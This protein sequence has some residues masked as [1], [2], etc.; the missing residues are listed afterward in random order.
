M[1][2]MRPVMSRVLRPLW[3]VFAGGVILLG[4]LSAGLRIALPLLAAQ[5]A[6]VE[7]W[8]SDL[9]H[10][11]VAIEGLGA[12]WPG[13]LPH[14][15]L[16]GLRIAPDTAGG[17]AITCRRVELTLAPLD[18][19]RAREPVLHAVTLDGLRLSVQRASDGRFSVQGIPS[20]NP[21]FLAWLLRQE[22]VEAWDTEIRFEDLAEANAPIRV[23]NLDLRLQDENG[24]LVARGRLNG[25]GLLGENAQFEL[26]RPLGPGAGTTTELRLALSATPIPE[27]LAAVGHPLTTETLFDHADGRLWLRWD[28]DRL[29]RVAADMKLSLAATRRMPGFELVHVRGV[30]SQ[31]PAG[32]AAQ[33]DTLAAGPSVEAGPGHPVTLT[34][35]Q[36]RGYL[37]ADALPLDLLTL[38]PHSPDAPAL[39]S[40]RGALEQIRAGWRWGATPAAFFADGQLAHGAVAQ[41]THTPAVEGVG[42]RYALNSN[43]G[44]LRLAPGAVSLEHAEHLVSRLAL[45]V[46]SAELHWARTADGWQFD[47]PA[48][49]GVLQGLPLKA[50]GSLAHDPDGGLHLDLDADLGPGPLTPLHTLLPVGLLHAR[51]EHWFRQAF[52]GGRLEGLELALHGRLADYPFDAGN[53]LFEL[54]FAVTDTG[55]LYSDKWPA[56]HGVSG[57]GSVR[58]RVLEAILT[59]TRFVDSPADDVLLRIPD[60]ASHEPR[61]SA[62]GRVH[63]TLAD[64]R[65]TLDESPLRETLGRQLQG[66]EIDGGFDLLLDLDI[67][68]RHDASRTASG[69]V[70]FQDNRLASA[71]ETLALENVT[72][73]IDFAGHQWRGAGLTARFDDMPITLAAE[74]GKSENTLAALHLEGEATGADI[75][76]LLARYAPG[77]HHWFDAEGKLGAFGG[78]TPWRA[79]LTLPSA[80]A[81]DTGRQLRVESSLAGLSVDLPWPFA[82]PAAT[83]LPFRLEAHFRPDAP[84]LTQLFLGNFAR[85]SVQQAP[86]A[87][88]SGLQG[89]DVALGD[90]EPA[91]QPADGIAIHGRARELPLGEWRALFAHGGSPVLD[92]PVAFDL[93]VDELSALGQRFPATRLHG[94]RGDGRWQAQIE[95]ERAAGSL[96]LDTGAAQPRL[97]LDLKHLQLA[98]LDTEDAAP[99]LDPRT[100]PTLSFRCAAFRYG[101]IDFGDTTLE[102]VKV[103]AGQ[104]LDRVRFRNPAFELE[105]QGSWLVE[106]GAQASELS[107]QLKGEALGKVLGTFGFAAAAIEDGRARLDIEASWPGMPSEFKLASLTGTL[108]LHVEQGRLLSVEPGSGRLFGLLSLQELPRRL[109]F[110]FNDLF[111]KGFAFDRIE[112]WFKLEQGNAYTNSLYME[113][114]SAKVEVSGRTGLLA[115]DYD[116]RAIVTP[117][118]SASLPIAGALFGPA[119]VGVGAALYLG[120]QVFKEVP[121]QVDRFLRREYTITGSW[122]E[123]KVEKR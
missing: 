69:R 74:G 70:L 61:L 13:L 110:D 103:A 111:A 50:T 105:G 17:A 116:Q 108:G 60:V 85:L 43:G 115:Q 71:R 23:Q 57:H 62:Q 88:G 95:G 10:I 54:D 26:R 34:L 97:T 120:Q 90:G 42:G 64:V 113:G 66:I 117:A 122:R 63:T 58:G 49:A 2:V 20:T 16:H 37:Q 76:R 81:A 79:T 78:I 18:S 123:P 75:G 107:L 22:R 100:L 29:A 47:L 56:A 6:S 38:L 102:S 35:E 21:V 83:H 72:G 65:A 8:A 25:A 94:H 104:Q 41:T 118:L 32:W 52:D 48:L 53:G 30:A 93:Q 45:Q 44:A 51:G 119:G 15:E 99:R 73:Q 31:V 39:P 109:S 3:P 68:L 89:L 77:V 96:E 28:G 24:R 121:A 82:K 46:E 55:L 86:A 9:M 40:L 92:L 14:L 98:R 12:R 27:V 112:G 4:L 36:E 101:D 1:P 59:A 114:P 67:G 106:G 19:L 7:H 11:P 84:H 87:S 5:R 33:L 80:S 91:R